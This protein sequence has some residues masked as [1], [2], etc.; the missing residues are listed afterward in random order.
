LEAA[1]LASP[2]THVDEGDPPL[3]ILHGEN[4]KVVK[5]DQTELLAKRY[6]E[7]GLRIFVHLEPGAGHG[8][9][10]TEEERFLVLTSLRKWFS[11]AD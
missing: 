7:T 9:P 11:D 6:H 1:R 10:T 2:V 4:D 5:L 8:W 3:L